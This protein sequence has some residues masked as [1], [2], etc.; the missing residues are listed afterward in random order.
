METPFV[1]LQFVS[2]LNPAKGF[3]ALFD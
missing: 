2:A 3:S 1:E